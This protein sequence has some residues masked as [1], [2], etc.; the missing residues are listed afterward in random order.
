MMLFARLLFQLKKIFIWFYGDLFIEDK[1]DA[2]HCKTDGCG[3]CV[4]KDG[5]Q[6][7]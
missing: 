3:N 2:G 7:K 4:L 1:I 6:W 5:C